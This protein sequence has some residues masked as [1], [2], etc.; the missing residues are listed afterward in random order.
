MISGSRW[1]WVRSTDERVALCVGQPAVN[2]HLEKLDVPRDRVHTSGARASSM[3]S[4]PPRIL[5]LT[6][7]PFVS[8]RGESLSNVAPEVR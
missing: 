6:S 3:V 5:R 8:R 2:L 4:R 7:N 1:R